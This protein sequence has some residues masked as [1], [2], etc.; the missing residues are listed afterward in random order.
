[1]NAEPSHWLHKTFISKIVCRCFGQ[2]NGAEK[3]PLETLPDFG[4]KGFVLLTTGFWTNFINIRKLVISFVV[5]VDHMSMSSTYNCK[6]SRLNGE[7]LNNPTIELC[8][9]L[10][11]DTLTH[12]WSCHLATRGSYPS[13]VEECHRTIFQAFILDYDRFFVCRTLPCSGRHFACA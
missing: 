7:T 10:F 3:Q 5:V 6:D 9:P 1:V 12:H 13:P 11:L 2:I 8:Q 4:V